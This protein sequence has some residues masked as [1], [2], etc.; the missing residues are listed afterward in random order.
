MVV[1]DREQIKCGRKLKKNVGEKNGGEKNGGE[2]KMWE[3]I[4]K[5]CEKIKKNVREK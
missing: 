1:A 4:K 3:K 2:N 5:I